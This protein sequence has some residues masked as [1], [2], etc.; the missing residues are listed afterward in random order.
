M[1]V[2]AAAQEPIYALSSVAL[3]PGDHV[4]A[5]VP[6]YQSLYEVARSRA[7]T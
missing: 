6:S 5:V 7:P 2:F 4:I 1:I 3:G